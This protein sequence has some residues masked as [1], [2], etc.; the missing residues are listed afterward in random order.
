MFYNYDDEMVSIEFVFN[1]VFIFHRDDNLSYE[2]HESF[3]SLWWDR[4]MG[5]SIKL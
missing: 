3:F 4:N 1:G 5:I 2:N